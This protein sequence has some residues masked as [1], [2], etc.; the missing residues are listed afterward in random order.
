[1]LCYPIA[2]SEF[3]GKSLSCGYDG[4][5]LCPTGA[6]GRLVEGRRGA[7][8]SA[9]RPLMRGKPEGW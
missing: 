1:M 3:D 5:C 9:K 7:K 8:M 4:P 2:M 6:T